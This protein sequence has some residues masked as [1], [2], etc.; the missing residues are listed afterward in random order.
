MEIMNR[1]KERR[2]S[3][4]KHLKKGSPSIIILSPF[5][6]ILSLLL[7]LGH[8]V[9]LKEHAS[10]IYIL[11]FLERTMTRKSCSFH[12]FSFSLKIQRRGRRER[13]R[14]GRRRE[15]RRIQV[16]C[17]FFLSS[18]KLP[19]RSTHDYHFINS[20]THHLV[21]LSFSSFFVS[22][23]FPS[24]CISCFIIPLSFQPRSLFFK[25]SCICIQTKIVT[26][27][28]AGEI[29]ES[30]RQKQKERKRESKIDNTNDV[31][32]EETQISCLKM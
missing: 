18:K 19:L 17:L 28:N 7:P 5:L 32:E 20:T 1:K 8:E 13:R 4:Q 12:P 26:N 2:R 23:L 11:F 10:K 31:R 3:K 22:T 27:N 25:C 16:P 30:K 15:R 9:E 29:F 6:S 21:F 14:R 24:I